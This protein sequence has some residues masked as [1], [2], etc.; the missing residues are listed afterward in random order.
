MQ[1]KTIWY[2][3]REVVENTRIGGRG[4]IEMILSVVDLQC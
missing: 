3:L 2:L 4:E 1:V